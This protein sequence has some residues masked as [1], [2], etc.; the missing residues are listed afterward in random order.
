MWFHD[1]LYNVELSCL[2]ELCFPCSCRRENG[3]NHPCCL[4]Y[5]LFFH[6]SDKS[7]LGPQITKPQTN[8]LSNFAI[9]RMTKAFS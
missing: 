5:P 8:K 4:I 6:I 2:F 7:I 9:E 1:L 3:V